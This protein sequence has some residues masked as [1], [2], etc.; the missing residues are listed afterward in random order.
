MIKVILVALIPLSSPAAGA[1]PTAFEYLKL[2]QEA[3]KSIN[4]QGTFVYAHDGQLESMRILH[5]ADQQGDYERIFHLNGSAREVVRENNVVTCILSDNKSV[6]INKRQSGNQ[7]LTL[8]PKDFDKFTHYY[9][10]QMGGHGRVANRDGVVV[11]VKPRDQF[12]YGYNL[13]LDRENSLLLKSELVNEGGHV[14]EQLMFT[15][16]NV[17]QDIP[18][19]EIRSN[20]GAAQSVEHDELFEQEAGADD[21]GRLHWKIGNMPQGFALTD[22]QKQHAT[23]GAASVQHMI[24][25]DGLA[26]VS[27]YIEKLAPSDKKFLGSSYMGAVNVFGAV[28]NDFQITVLG[29][30]PKDTVKMVAESMTYDGPAQ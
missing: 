10:V 28:V 24:L 12:R 23:E 14:I 4:Y 16:I 18:V 1:E 9:D 27:V 22:H 25:S 29:E 30:V 15:E 7:L 17:V 3:A 19:S 6:V 8:F 21:A 20:L 26:S 2:M 11:I 5:K 13:W